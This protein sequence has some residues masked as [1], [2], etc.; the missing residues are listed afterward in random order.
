[1]FGLVLFCFEAGSHFISWAGLELA[2]LPQHPECWQA[3]CSV[4]SNWLSFLCL[5]KEASCA[6]TPLLL[7]LGPSLSCPREDTQTHSFLALEIRFIALGKS[8]VNLA[9]EG[10]CSWCWRNAAR[11]S[12]PNGSWGLPHPT[13]EA[14][15]LLFLCIIWPFL[16]CV[17]TP[18][19]KW[20]LSKVTLQFI[21]W[22]LFQMPNTEPTTL[23]TLWATFLV[24]Q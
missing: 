6:R 21:T 22:N 1:M 24:K 15:Q 18:K 13:P 7:F 12:H 16:V 8:V 4:H 9:W 10:G 17:L 2:T 3:V 14:E 11:A 20:R 5:E 23:V 19:K